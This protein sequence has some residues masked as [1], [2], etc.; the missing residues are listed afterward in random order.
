MAS[1]DCLTVELSWRAHTSTR[2]ILHKFVRCCPF[3]TWFTLG[4]NPVLRLRKV[5]KIVGWKGEKGSHFE[6]FLGSS[7]SFL[8]FLFR[9]T[10]TRAY[11]H[12]RTHDDILEDQKRLRVK[13]FKVSLWSLMPFSSVN[14]EISANSGCW[15][16]AVVAIFP[17]KSLNQDPLTPARYTTPQQRGAQS[18]FRTT[19]NIKEIT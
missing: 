10:F 17:L 3:S 1:N 11:F 19:F 18:L 13:I 12:C 8:T 7:S 4:S 5:G 6:G 16:I 15:K 2:S 14:G 9:P